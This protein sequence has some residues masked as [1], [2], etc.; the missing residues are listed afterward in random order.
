[1]RRW[2]G[3]QHGGGDEG[4][5]IRVP[6]HL[7]MRGSFTQLNEAV[8]GVSIGGW[9]AQQPCSDAQKA[10]WQMNTHCEPGGTGFRLTT[11]FRFRVLYLSS[12]QPSSL[13]VMHEGLRGRL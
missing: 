9:A 11:G 6:H 12:R 7:R 4:R 2:S 8:L 5:N 1:M 10:P 13:A 3:G